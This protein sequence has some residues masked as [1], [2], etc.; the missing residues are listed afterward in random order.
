[1]M[2]AVAALGSTCTGPTATNAE[3]PL[4]KRNGWN[5]PP[6]IDTIRVSAS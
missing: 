2:V 4:G 6:V 5:P 1:M 3:V